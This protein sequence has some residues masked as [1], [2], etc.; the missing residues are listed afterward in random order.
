MFEIHSREEALEAM[1]NFEADFPLCDVNYGNMLDA[2]QD[3]F[4]TEEQKAQMENAEYK[5]ALS[6]G[7]D[8]EFARF[9]YYAERGF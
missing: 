5:Y 1:R 8:P 4:M 9:F 3:F 7:I 2:I 6:I